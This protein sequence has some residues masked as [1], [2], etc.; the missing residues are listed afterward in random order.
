M[1]EF[2][3]YKTRP[4]GDRISVLADGAPP[5]LRDFI[6]DVIHAGRMLP[7]DWLYTKAHEAFAELTADSD[8]D[9]VR[10]WADN[11]VDIYYKDMLAWLVGPLE[12][13]GAVDEVL[14]DGVKINLSQAIQFAQFAELERIGA[15]VVEFLRENG[16]V[17]N[18]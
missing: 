16:E 4:N 5:E 18:D 11:A 2:F 17:D 7:D 3:A 14:S 12:N 8:E 1:S 13:W 9:T 15:A 6:R 10:E